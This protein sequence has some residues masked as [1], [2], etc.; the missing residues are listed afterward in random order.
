MNNQTTSGTTHCSYCKR[1]LNGPPEYGSFCD[2]QCA[3]EAQYDGGGALRGGKLS[4]A[5]VDEILKYFHKLATLAGVKFVDVI[6]NYGLGTDD[7]RLH[8]HGLKF[9][10][11]DAH[12]CPHR[13]YEEEINWRLRARKVLRP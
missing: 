8:Q 1:P 12:D 9:T 3:F 2:E 4:A 7:E 10:Y 6:I 5:Q 11:P 13:K